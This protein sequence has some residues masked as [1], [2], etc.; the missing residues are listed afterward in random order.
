M[1]YKSLLPL[2]LS[3]LLLSGC[4][5]IV[6]WGK[7]NFKQA[8]KLDFKFRQARKDLKSITVYDQLSTVAMFDVL[9]LS[10]DV[11]I[12]YVDLHAR[13]YGKT[14]EQ[15]RAMLRRQLAENSHFIS[16][17][18]AVPYEL[19]LGETNSRWSLSLEIDDKR[20]L[21]IEVKVIDVNPEYKAIF[22][23]KL[24]R[25]K[26]VYSVRFDAKNVEE[27]PLITPDTHELKLYFRSTKKEVILTWNIQD[28]DQPETV[29]VGE[30]V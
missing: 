11:R 5:R 15:K 28:E 13:K 27:R 19:I 2:S 14:E 25:F 6:D 9:G 29:V 26:N 7:G 22:G 17:Y 12:A 18:V 20:Y 21:P 16:F 23:K 24:S 10:D 1:K 8:E 3:L 30:T 4:G